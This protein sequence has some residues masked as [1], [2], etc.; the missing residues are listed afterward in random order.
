M[1]GYLA[2]SAPPRIYKGTHSLVGS[3]LLFEV[4]YFGRR[5]SGVHS[6]LT[7]GW[8]GVGIAIADGCR[9]HCFLI[10]GVWRWWVCWNETG[11][12][13]DFIRGTSP[14][15]CP[16]SAP[17]FTQVL[18]V[19]S[20]SPFCAHATWLLFTFLIFCGGLARQF[21]SHEGLPLFDWWTFLN[22]VWYR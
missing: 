3:I 4:D 11:S 6:R 5:Q 21:Q 22:D 16:C 8:L 9:G 18:M 19:L 13:N 1:W 14:S 15:L 20:I 7:D 2:T 12:T 17:Q 10:V